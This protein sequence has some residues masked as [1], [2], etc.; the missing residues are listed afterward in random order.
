MYVNH[1]KKKLKDDCTVSRETV[2]IEFSQI[3]WFQ[4]SRWE[5]VPRERQPKALKTKLAQEGPSGC[6]STQ[7]SLFYHKRWQKMLRELENNSR[8]PRDLVRK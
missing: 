5:A 8:K 6:E 2:L 7:L 4:N 3:R 1:P